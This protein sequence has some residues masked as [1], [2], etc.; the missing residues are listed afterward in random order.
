MKMNKW[1]IAVG[2]LV[3]GSSVRA[4][5]PAIFKAAFK[6]A[7]ADGNGKLTE[8]ELRA[9]FWKRHQETGA[10]FNKNMAARHIEEMDKDG[11]GMI[12]EAEWNEW[13]DADIVPI[14]G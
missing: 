13:K 12:S 4:A 6:A 8:A 5:D 14:V 7:D 3:V 9:Y 11:D 10:K 1:V 2:L